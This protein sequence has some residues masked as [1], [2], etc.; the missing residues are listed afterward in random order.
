M[1][2][3]LYKYLVLNDQVCVPGVGRFFKERKPAQLNF[4]NKEFEPPVYS[5][6]FRGEQVAADK[7]FFAFLTKE[8][9]IDELQAVRQFHEFA[10]DL[11]HHI[12][13]H[14]QTELPGLGWLKRSNDGAI[15]FEPT[16]L[17]HDYFTPTPAERIVRENVE[18]TI[19]VGD[20]ERTNTEMQEML[21]DGAT[22]RPKALWWIIAIVLALIAIAA[23]VFYYLQNGNLR[24]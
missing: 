20:T 11:K 12:N 23:I 1:F 19:L 3:L 18:H 16:S 17:T 5:I 2:P 15:T 21:D 9:G 22:R 7:S 14:P 6:Q 13:N 10:F 8:Q 4:S 24:M